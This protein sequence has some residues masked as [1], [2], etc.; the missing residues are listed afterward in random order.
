MK[1]KT[2]R[3][4]KMESCHSAQ[5]PTKSFVHYDGLKEKI[6]NFCKKML[7]ESKDFLKQSFYNMA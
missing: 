3:K 7:S 5:I 2:E 6:L 4:M 1:E